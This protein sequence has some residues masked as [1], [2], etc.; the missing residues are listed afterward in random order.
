MAPLTTAEPVSPKRARSMTS[1]SVSAS[2]APLPS[3]SSVQPLPSGPVVTR[4]SAHEP[5]TISVALT[6][7]GEFD[8]AFCF[9][10]TYWLSLMVED[11]VVK[12]STLHAE[13]LAV[14]EM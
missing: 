8:A 6:C 10:Q 7:E 4:K 12:A 2:W 11:A 13:Q 3:T 14:P 9:R 1:P 5:P